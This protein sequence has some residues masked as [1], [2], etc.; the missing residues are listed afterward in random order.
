MPAAPLNA[1]AVFARVVEC[2]SFS[3]AAQELGMTP[4]AVSRHV[5]RLEATLG[6]SLLQRTT[7]A[8][9]LTELG[10]S[11]YAACAR[12]TAAAREVTA[13][14]G[15]HTGEPHGVLR[16]SAPVSFGQAWLAPRLPALLARYPALELQIT[17][18]DRMVDLVEEGLDVAIRIARELAPGLVARPL[19]EVHYRLVASPA[20]VRQH[21]APATPNDLPA[22]RCLYLGYGA[23]GEHWTLRPKAGGDSLSVR[24]PPR[25]TLNNSLA[26][27]TMVERDAG[28]GLVPDFSAADGL[29]D[30]RLVT[31]LDD[32]DILE[33]YVGTAYAVY[34]PTR[35]V[36]PK[37]R[38]FVDHLAGS[39]AS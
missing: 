14:G 5:S 24:I 17:L 31:V 13:L 26:I 6:A 22:A 19:R 1:M 11:V 4:S 12:M 25:L 3:A 39:G 28:I 27:V 10:Q 33:P 8:F 15:D 29:A 34:T 37:V 32:W 16:V 18:A 20:Y 9:A 7:R 21:G 2:G 36:A 38:A 23:F 35:H 30:G